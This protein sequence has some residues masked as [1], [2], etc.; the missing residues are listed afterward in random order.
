M[1][2]VLALVG[3]PG[4]RFGQKDAMTTE[5]NMAPG[6]EA[7]PGTENTGENLCPD[8]SGKGERDGRPCAT[9]EG[10][11]TVIAGVGGG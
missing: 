1:N 6:D 9:C 7:P 4:G 10:T 11:G 2:G 5:P 3:I 8:C